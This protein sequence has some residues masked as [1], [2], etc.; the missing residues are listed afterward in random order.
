M[1]V[2]AH[3]GELLFLDFAN[4]P[5]WVEQDVD[6]VDIVESLS[7]S[8]AC[9]AAG[10]DED[11]GLFVAEVAD[12]PCKEA[13]ADVLEGEG[14][15]VEEFESESSWVGFDEGNGKLIASAQMRSRSR[16]M[17]PSA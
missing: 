12:G 2:A 8:T 6:A 15:A 10:G 14:R 1:D 11:R 13:C 17:E 16:S 7:D 5:F 4:A 9:V 3:G